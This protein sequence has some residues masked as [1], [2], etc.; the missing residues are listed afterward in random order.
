MNKEESCFELSPKYI[1][2]CN[3]VDDVYV[4]VLEGTTASG[5][6]TVAA[7]IKFMRMVS[8]SDKKEH[9]IAAR[10]VGVAE[11]NIINQD[12]GILDIHKNATYCGNGDKENKFPHIKFEGKIIYILS[13]LCLVNHTASRA[14][15]YKPFHTTVIISPLLY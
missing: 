9:I 5:K 1:D 10:T 13:I 8:I 15:N 14:Y 12:N 4:D 7:G 3:T 2:F 11:K 6:T